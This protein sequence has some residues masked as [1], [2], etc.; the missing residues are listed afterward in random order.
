V[1]VCVCVLP[2]LVFQREIIQE[3]LLWYQFYELT[4]QVCVQAFSHISN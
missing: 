2:S 1:C 4:R 3:S